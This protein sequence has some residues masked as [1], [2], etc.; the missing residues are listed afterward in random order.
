[1][2][3]EA[4]KKKAQ[5]LVEEADRLYLEA[6]SPQE[7]STWAKITLSKMDEAVKL[8]PDNAI[9]W[10]LRG[11]AKNILGDHQGATDDF[12]KAI[13]ID[14]T[15]YIVWTNQ[16]AA[17]VELGNYQGAIHSYSEAIKL[18]P[19][20]APAW[21]DRGLAKINI[22]DNQGAIDDCTKAIELDPKDFS[23]WT[24]RGGAKDNIGDH[25][26]AIDD[27]TKAIEINSEY[28]PAWNNRGAAKNDL[29]D[30]QGAIEDCT[31]A[32]EIN[33]KDPS[34]WSNRG[35]AKYRLGRYADARKDLDEALNLNP[36]NETL[37]RNKQA[38]T[39]AMEDEKQAKE[40]LKKESDYRKEL[41]EKSKQFHG[42]YD[43]CVQ[44]RDNLFRTI[45]KIIAGYI[46]CLLIVIAIVFGPG[47]NFGDLLKHPFGLLPYFALLFIILSPFIWRI[48][49]STKEAE[50]NLTLREDYDARL[51]IE[52]Y[53]GRFFSDRRGRHEFAP[54]YMN[55]WMYNNPSETLI[56]L[57]NKSKETPELPQVEQIRN[58]T[59][60][61]PTDQ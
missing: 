40:T 30:H 27:C 35:T 34:A 50:R 14:S 2:A 9:A 52:S 22:G 49:I 60:N 57:A 1:M 32:I 18:N 59:K 3:S 21:G 38:I 5:E 43:K 20:F 11:T 23:A 42:N 41:E 24:N 48:S 15:N 31:K 25:Q 29:D 17:K 45:Q 55:Y 47:W 6:R 8:D 7:K 33:P 28:A 4:D 61:T 36:N 26:G 46:L 44:E 53:L 51:M 54:K 56:R 39:L 13:E 12:T 37:L 16:G 19:N 10:F 58:F